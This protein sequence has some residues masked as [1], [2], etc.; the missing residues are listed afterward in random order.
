MSTFTVKVHRVTVTSH[1]GADRLDIAHILGFQTCIARD[2]L[3]SGDLAAY[4]PDGAIV[5]EPLL[6]EL[7][8]TGKL[9][10]THAN[11][12]KPI[13]LR[14]VLS[15]GLVVG[16]GYAALATTTLSEGQDVTELL[17]ITK[18][19]PR[20]PE[21][22][23]GQAVPAH[24]DCLDFDV[25]DFKAH[26][27][28]LEDG[29]AVV[30]TEKLHGTCTILGVNAHGAPIATSKGLSA[31][32]LKF[33]LDSDVN[34][35]NLYVQMWH[36]HHRAVAEIHEKVGVP[37]L[38]TYVLGETVGIGLQNLGYGIRGLRFHAFDICI[39][40]RRERLWLPQERMRKYCAEHHIPVVPEIARCAFNTKTIQALANGQSEVD[41][42]T[43]RRE[44]IVVRT[45][46]DR[47]DPRLG[48]VILKMVSEPYLAKSGRTEYR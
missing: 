1:P 39:G 8:L 32:G 30:V 5:P 3:R 11:R 47:T 40:N 34:A 2:S 20:V 21:S 28:V 13:L 31:N 18:F 16:T 33:D 27:H 38:G 4:I 42:A 29:E 19:E 43:H 35:E 15:E 17:G 25:E 10:G 37:G 48:R 23:T 14:G 24:E 9:A 36:R 41:G 22:L 12:V 6:A 45:A 44:G 7:G 26:P 46:Q